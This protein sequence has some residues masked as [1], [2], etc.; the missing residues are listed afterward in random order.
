MWNFVSIDW[1][2]LLTL[3][4]FQLKHPVSPF[5]WCSL[6]LVAIG[7]PWDQI[8]PFDVTQSIS[9]FAAFSI[10]NLVYPWLVLYMCF[11]HSHT[12]LSFQI[13]LISN[14]FIIKMLPFTQRCTQISRGILYLF[15][16][17]Y[18]LYLKTNITLRWF[19][20]M[21]SKRLQVLYIG[22]ILSSPSQRTGLAGP[23]SPSTKQVL[24]SN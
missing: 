15:C 13:F 1:E 21:C 6:L 3:Y 16:L 9:Y 4:L 12:F 14:V 10:Y 20:I 11:I 23:A 24:H 2:N 5:S 8:S 7:T 17:T 19:E 22:L 18:G